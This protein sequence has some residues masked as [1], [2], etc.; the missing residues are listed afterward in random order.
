[1]V[2]FSNRARWVREFGSCGPD[3]GDGLLRSGGGGATALWDGIV[4]S[5]AALHWGSGRP[6]LLLFTD[7]MDIL[8]WAWERHIRMAVQ[9]SEVLL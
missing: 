6:A 1:M 2:A 9:A 7:G 8:S 5:P 3:V 4:L